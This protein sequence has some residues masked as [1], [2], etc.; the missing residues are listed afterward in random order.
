MHTATSQLSKVVW[1]VSDPE[2][3]L[4]DD[5]M[6]HMF[7]LLAER[8]TVATEAL[9]ADDREIARAVGAEGDFEVLQLELEELVERRMLRRPA[10]ELG[11]V[12]RLT[13][14]LRI[15][16]ELE[17]A[18]GLV[19]QI[20]MRAP[21]LLTAELSGR[22]RC[23]LHEMGQTARIMWCIAA[24]AYCDLDASG[25]GDLRDL[26]EALGYMRVE[27]AVELAQRNTSVASA[28]QLG[29]VARHYERLGDHALR[30]ARR[31]SRPAAPEVD[32]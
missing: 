3:A 19:E 20:G 6:A 9:L 2:F 16:P 10:P 25:L 28:I 32:A 8:V 17:L 13:A 15:A 22:A 7:G 4:I 1:D 30:V 27:L 12:R 18:A 5:L 14:T 29:L 21:Q 11:E 31:A 23:L 24:D 26:H